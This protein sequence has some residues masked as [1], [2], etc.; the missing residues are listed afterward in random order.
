MVIKD[1]GETH[2]VKSRPQMGELLL[3]KGLVTQ[4]QLTE[5]IEHQS[6]HGGRLGD[7]L[8]S[9]GYIN[10][11]QLEEIIPK[12]VKKQAI[13]ELLVEKGYISREQLEFALAF[14]KKS[15]G[16]MGDILLSLN[17]VSTE[18]LF[19]ELATQNKV[20]RV[21]KLLDFK[22]ALKLPHDVARRYNA[23]LVND[24]N[25][26]YLLAVSEILSQ[27]KVRDIETYLDK[28]VEQVLAAR[29]EL[30]YYWN[31]VYGGDMADESINKLAQEQP[32]NS[33]LKTFTK[34]QIIFFA[35]L[36]LMTVVFYFI[37]GLTTLIASN[38]IV[39]L[40]YFFMSVFKLRI[41]L[42]GTRSNAQIRISKREV[43]N[44]DETK[45]P[46]YT[47]LVPM[48]REKEV[49]PQL[50]SHI[51]KID[52]PKSKLDVRLLLEEDD[53]ESYEVI[54]S[55]NLP[56][57][58]TTIV[59][60]HSLPK[61]KP[62]ACNYGLIRAR[63][64]Y[65]VI[66]DAE[67]RPDPDQLKKVCL[68]FEK[69]PEEYICVQA[70]LNYYNSNQ[71]LLTKWFT[72]EY[73]MWFELLLPGVM[74]LDIPIP[75]GGTS[76]HFKMDYLKKINAWD[77]YNV[78]EDADLGVRIFKGGYKTAVVDSRTWEEAN[79]QLR[80]WLRQRS[81]WI[82][83]Y[84]Q[85]WLVHMRNPFRLLKELG[86]KGFLGFQV[87]VLGTPLLTLLNPFFWL[88]VIL[89]YAF[90]P[91]WIQMLFPGGIYYIA[92][93]QLVIGNFIFIYSNVLGM[94]WIIYEMSVE[95]TTVFSY[96][97][98]KYALLTPV[99]WLLMSVAAFKAFGQLITRP[100]YWEKTHHGLTRDDSSS[101]SGIMN[102]KS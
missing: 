18:V 15:G 66:Y 27:D 32:E 95:K 80:N 51:D 45:L 41:L 39:Q 31:I 84:M 16:M 24:Q 101:I 72:M 13:G 21:G 96:K 100:F 102:I 77:P 12:E 22:N 79:S 76:N 38:I 5:A 85:T 82:K 28:P 30:D 92:L 88:L 29:S 25:N 67:D 46:I 62:K 23:I 1:T 6:N 54:K 94:Y 89:W 2:N 69:L 26:R 33:A 53:N 3:A 63:G 64:K 90:K 20:G 58:Y 40:I 73:S 57:Y 71:N 43:E 56:A 17:M 10:K 60:P 68:T 75:L 35:A 48:Y 55:M 83:G 86:L 49:I 4:E 42:L 59:V 93:I 61:T 11:E 14:Q 44:I 65:V 97:Y 81:R 9:L 34:P 74:K 8:L 50:I 78:T 91:P 19:R 87:M 70:K 99:Y 98:I 7:I 37:F 36:P 47:I 52:Y